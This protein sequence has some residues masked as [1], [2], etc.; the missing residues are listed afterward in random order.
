MD[1]EINAKVSYEFAVPVNE[2]VYFE[3]PIY[4]VSTTEYD[5]AQSNEYTV[6]ED[7]FLY[8]ENVESLNGAKLT[9]IQKEFSEAVDQNQNYYQELVNQRNKIMQVMSANEVEKVN[10]LEDGINETKRFLEPY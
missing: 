9:V 8:G 2:K 5:I 6:G 10:T 1:F 3:L 4:R 7:V